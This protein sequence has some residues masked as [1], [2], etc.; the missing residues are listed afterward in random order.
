MAADA[1]A[2]GVDRLLQPDAEAGD[3]ISE[4]RGT[5]VQCGHEK[6]F[7]PVV[8]RRFSGYVQVQMTATTKERKKYG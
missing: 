4:T 8:S 6:E 7:E 2:R 3:N 5:P 1:G